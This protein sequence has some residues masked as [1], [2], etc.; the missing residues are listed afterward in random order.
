MLQL[1]AATAD[2]FVGTE[3]FDDVGLPDGVAG[4]FGGVAIDANL[5][6]HDGA[7]GLFTALAKATFDQ[8][9]IQTHAASGCQLIAPF[10]SQACLSGVIGAHPGTAPERGSVTRSN[11]QIQGRVRLSP[12]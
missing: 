12:A 8:N 6:G 3:Q 11:V 2:E 10:A 1:V 4:F 7:F 9:L 5:S